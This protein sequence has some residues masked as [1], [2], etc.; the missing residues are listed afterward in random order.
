MINSTQISV[1]LSRLPIQQ[2]ALAHKF[3]K[4]SDVKITASAYLNGFFV[5]L[6]KGQNTIGCWASELSYALGEVISRSG[7]SN[8]IQYPQV[9]FTKSLLEDVLAKK[10]LGAQHKSL[11]SHLLKHFERVLVED[12]VCISLPKVL[13]EIFPGAHSKTGQA[14]TARIQYRMDIK[15]GSTHRLE[16]QSFRDN[17]AKFSAD[18][19]EDLK[20]GDLVIRDLGYWSLKVFR[21]IIKREAFLLTRLRFGTNL[22]DADTQA[23]IDLNEHLKNADQKN[24]KV[25]KIN[26][27]VGAKERLPLRLVAIKAPA[28]V[29]N[30]RRRKA[31]KNRDQRQNHSQAYMELL[32]WTIFL[33]NVEEDVWTPQQMLE[34]YGFRWRIE[35]VFK[36]WK[37]KLN[38]QRLFEKKQSIS[39]PRAWITIYLVMLWIIMFFIPVFNYMLIKVYE[40]TGKWL[41]ILKFA[42]FFKDHFV[43]LMSDFTQKRNTDFWVK[44][45]AK[46][47]TYEK[48]KKIK[49]FYEKLYMLNFTER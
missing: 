4:Q 12:S 43:E 15:D 49:N 27:L 5:M 45:I 34:V 11:N 16:V 8:K 35:I 25:I 18:I 38:L 13:H 6:S 21:G 29:A 9:D 33:T 41:S 17:D 14:A 28:K 42:Q 44:L 39:P 32:D 1:K 48:R 30:E 47:C 23:H 24:I 20:P 31:K 10:I 19:L 7:L 3:S 40:R 37:S 36:A 26:V 46:H 22:Y 2:V